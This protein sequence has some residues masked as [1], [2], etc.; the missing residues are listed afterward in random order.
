MSP[1]FAVYAA[2]AGEDAGWS[3]G[4][5]A[6]LAAVARVVLTGLRSEAC[7]ADCAAASAEN[8]CGFHRRVA[9]LNKTH[10]RAEIAKIGERRKVA[11]GNGLIA[12][13]SAELHSR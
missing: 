4:R 6:G 3:A 13:L 9:T 10:E 5:S 1:R 7:G 12:M 11:S 8:M 2:V